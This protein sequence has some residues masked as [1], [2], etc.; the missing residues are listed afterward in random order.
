MYNIPPLV[1]FPGIFIRYIPVQHSSLFYFQGY[2]LGIYPYNIP[3]C[4]ISRD[5]AG[6][7][8]FRTITTAYYRGAMVWYT[9]L[10]NQSCKTPIY[11][12]HR[13]TQNT[14]IRKTPI[15]AKHRFTQNTDIRKTPIY[16][17][18]R[19]TQNTD[20]R[21]TPIYSKHRFTQNTDLRKTRIYSKH[22]FTQNINLLNKKKLVQRNR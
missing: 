20:L 6:Q 18:H 21:K 5:T 14:D 1:L 22:E 10:T 12:K 19:F 2:L 16:S 8:R 9:V 11:A 4:F 13:Y 15:Y 3:P 17:K 7:E